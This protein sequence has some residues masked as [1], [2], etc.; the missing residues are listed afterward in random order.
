MRPRDRVHA[1]RGKR[2]SPTGERASQ[3]LV[4]VEQA[5]GDRESALSA[6]SRCIIFKK[7]YCAALPLGISLRVKR[8]G[9]LKNAPRL[10]WPAAAAAAAFINISLTSAE[11]HLGRTL[12]FPVHRA[13]SGQGG[14]APL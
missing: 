11:R 9:Q 1:A 3:E 14:D 5:G 13:D 10:R 12:S 6:M 8:E 4:S 2:K 7:R